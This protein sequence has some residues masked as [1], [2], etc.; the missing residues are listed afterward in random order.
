MLLGRA[1]EAEDLA[2]QMLKGF[3]RDRVSAQ[4]ALVHNYFSVLPAQLH[5]LPDDASSYCLPSDD[6]SMKPESGNCEKSG[7]TAYIP[8]KAWHTNPPPK[9]QGCSYPSM[10][11]S[12]K[13]RGPRYH[14]PEAVAVSLWPEEINGE[15]V[16]CHKIQEF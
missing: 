16:T 2:S 4:E 11:V 7:R 12:M 8:A 1:P 9:R 6:L 5:Q 10:C 3:P 13:L 15:G 14:C